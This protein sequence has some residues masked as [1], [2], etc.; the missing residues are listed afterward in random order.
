MVNARLEHNLAQDW[1]SD[2]RPWMS[3]T[4]GYVGY[5]IG[6]TEAWSVEPGLLG[7]W[8]TADLFNTGNQAIVTMAAANLYYGERL[9]L[10]TS[11]R[12]SRHLEG[13]NGSTPWKQGEALR[14]LLYVEA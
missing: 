1:Q 13:A 14:I 3:G 7:E 12:L 5:R 4:H 8:V 11:F 9:R 6:S 10:M 2:T